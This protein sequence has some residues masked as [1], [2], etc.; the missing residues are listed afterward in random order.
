MKSFAVASFA[1]LA[2]ASPA[3]DA[4]DG[5]EPVAPVASSTWAPLT[6]VA[7]STWVPI[8]TPVAPAAT[9]SNYGDYDSAVWNEWNANPVYTTTVVTAITTYC[10]APTTMVHAGKTYTITKATTLTITD[11]PCTISVP[12]YVKTS[13][14]CDTPV[15]A[16][17]TW[18]NVPANGAQTWANTPVAAASTWANTPVA[19]ASTWA[20]YPAGSSTTGW[21]PVATY[22]G[23]ADK[24]N[25]GAGLAGVV[26]LAAL[27]L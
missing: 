6:P 1:A 10:P 17:T 12:V 7:Q 25:V 16:Q 20:G 26:G 9:W 8:T 19:A 13:T 21:S 4:R 24:V 5:W 22:K 18:A 27:L 14:S 15:A 3:L 2:V 23:A 11:C